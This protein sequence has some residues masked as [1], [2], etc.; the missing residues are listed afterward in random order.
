MAFLAKQRIERNLLVKGKKKNQ[1]WGTNR[2]GWGKPH[3][4]PSG[5]QNK[6]TSS[7]RGVAGG[8]RGSCRHARGR[9]GKS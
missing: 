6:T 2:I 3:L 1:V 8:R 9:S 7:S 5:A 4:G